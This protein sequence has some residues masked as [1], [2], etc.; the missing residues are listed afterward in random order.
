M[1]AGPPLHVYKGEDFYVPAFRVV[2]EGRELL[3]EMGDIMSLTYTDKL[4]AIDS[5][6]MTVNNWDAE[7]LNFKYSDG[8]TFNPWKNVE[9]SMGYFLNGQDNRKQML[10][11]DIT[12]LAPNFP[13][14]GGPTLAVSGLSLLHR[15]RLKQETMQFLKKKDTEIAQELVKKIAAEVR[16]TSPQ[17]TVQLDPKDL[18]T[19]L[20]EEKPVPYLTIH[21]KYPI[22]FLL[23][24][25]RRIGY[26]F[27]VKETG[28][29]KKR[30]VTISFHRTSNVDQTTYILEWGKSLISFQPT[31]QTA[32][33][34]SKVIV[35]GWDPQGKK[36]FE[37]EATRAQ[38]GKEKVVD[39]LDLGVTEPNLSKSMEIV[40]DRPI[41]SKHEADELAKNTLLQL[42]KDLVEAKGKTIG[43]PA[44]RSGVKLD[45][46]GLGSR[47]SGTYLVTSTTH[48]I[49]DGGYTTDFSARMEKS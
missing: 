4:D 26:E 31:L 17:V 48:T 45:I 22:L 2:I 14:S 29:D 30:L 5:F 39:P 12:N 47:F 16:K 37:G 7:K 15:F 24:R 42:T 27:A 11:G 1:A 25:A 28:A 9:I 20:K 18:E 41:Q 3:G 8:A 10:I 35:R 21:N 13:S 38:L 46:K 6:E 34:V 49:G 40:A 44:L 36:A 23:E 43:L 19:N 33:Q 32:R